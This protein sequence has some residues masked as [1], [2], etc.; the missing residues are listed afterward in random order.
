[1]ASNPA[2]LI[3]TF[4]DIPMPTS[5]TKNRPFQGQKSPSNEGSNQREK[6]P[7]YLWGNVGIRKNGKLVSLPM[8]IA[9]DKSPDIKVPKS[10][11]E[12]QDYYHLQ[13]ARKRL[14][15]IVQEK[16]NSLKPGET[17]TLPFE[18]EIRRVAETEANETENPVENPY[19]IGE[20][21]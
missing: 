20:L 1:M 12:N 2:A 17:M 15:D 5:G 11:I 4:D 8:G 10:N 9:L 7:V 14:W 3:T 21:F 13:V 18:F 6:T 19:D 16:M